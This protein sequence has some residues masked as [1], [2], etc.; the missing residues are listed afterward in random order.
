MV[1]L[2]HMLYCCP[3]I[4]L[5]PPSRFPKWEDFEYDHHAYGE[6]DARSLTS[7]HQQLQ[8]FLL[9]RI[10]KDVEKSLPA[11]VCQLTVS[12]S[13]IRGI[14][15]LSN[16]FFLS[17]NDTYSIP[18]TIPVFTSVFCSF[19]LNRYADGTVLWK[20]SNT[21]ANSLYAFHDVHALSFYKIYL[22]VEQILRVDMSST[23]RQYYK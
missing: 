6:G 9:R 2:A 5:E 11:K 17:V 21:V 8:P 7:L 22:Q 1:S 13:P 20:Y 4:S 3:K 19:L 15:P 12:N 23:Q 18:I 16:V 14:T 10:K